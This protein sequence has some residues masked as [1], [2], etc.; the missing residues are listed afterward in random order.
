[1]NEYQ[2]AYGQQP[3]P[4]PNGVRAGT[5]RARRARAKSGKGCLSAVIVVGL[6][7]VAVG[8]LAGAAVL[9]AVVVAGDSFAPAGGLAV[10]EKVLHREEGATRKI[11]VV[12]VNGVIM[13][14][15]SLQ[16]SSSGVIKTVLAQVKRD[17]KVAAVILNLDTPGGEVTASDEIYNAVVSLDVPVVACMRAVCAS[18]GYYVAA[19]ADHVVANEVSLTGSIGVIIPRYR[20]HGLLEKIGVE[21]A[22]VKSGDMKDMLSGARER[23]PE[24]KAAIDAYVQGLVDEVFRRFCTVVA[25]GRDQ[26]LTWEDVRNAPFGDGRIVLGRQAMELGLVDELGYF[27]HAVDA[28]KRLAGIDAANVVRFERDFT[29]TEILFSQA[30]AGMKLNTGL[31]S[32]LPKLHPTRMYYLMPD[33]VE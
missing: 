24:R 32:A 6:V 30:N 33:L 19:G 2:S 31:E 29:F 12:D 11:A 7:V 3:P 18:G 16:T 23:S 27:E 1:M 20:Y 5:P 17:P 13:G 15:D 9:A 21:T 28:A 14:G 22:A 26:F 4:P 25:E 10:S 8:V